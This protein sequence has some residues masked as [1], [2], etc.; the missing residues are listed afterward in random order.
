[1][2]HIYPNAY[3][4]G[5]TFKPVMTENDIQSAFPNGI[6]N[7]G[8]I[9]IHSVSVA[10]QAAQFQIGGVDENMLII[11]FSNTLMPN[12]RRQIDITFTVKL[13]NVRHRLG[14]FGHTVNLGNFF[15]IAAVYESGAFTD[16]PYYAFGDPFYS[17]AANFKVSITKPAKYTAAMS[18]AVTRT[19]LD[20][21]TAKSV[22]EIRAARDFAVVLGEFTTVSAQAGEATVLYYYKSDPTP[23]LSLQA[24]VDSIN[25]FNQL[26]GAYPYATFSVVETAF[27]QGGM[28]YPGLV[29]ISDALSGALY[30]EVIIHEA[31]H[32]WWYAVVGNN[33]IDHPWLDEGLAEYSTALF[34]EFNPSYGISKEDRILRA[35]QGLYIYTDIYRTVLRGYVPSMNR[36]SYEY[37][38]DMEYYYMTYVKGGLLFD[39]IRHLIGD[40]AFFAALKKYYADNKF[41]VATPDD[42]IGAFEHASGKDLGGI[43]RAWLE[44][45]VVH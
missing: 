37:A 39:S 12:H 29:L 7:Y 23:E 25:T 14:W 2:L 34:Y 3:R 17:E 13:A 8:S 44:G 43:F 18:G 28:E 26:F 38:D 4:E 41:K 27:L 36:K 1:M 6:A 22:S 11:P 21:G 19:E 16:K 9:T 30:R 32:Q 20:N 10:G 5:A 24:A 40:K 45:N 33:Q 35:I 42:L 31:A 15:P